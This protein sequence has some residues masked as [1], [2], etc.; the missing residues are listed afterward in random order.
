MKEFILLVRLPLEYGADQAS[1]VR[2][3][4]TA[5]TDQWKSDA[6]FVTSFVFPGE[7]HIIS[8]GDKLSKEP[9][10]SDNRRLI[11]CIVL[12]AADLKTALALANKCPVLA[13]EGMI[14]LREIMPRVLQ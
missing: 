12:K 13:Q 10:T 3:Q 9:A 6:L 11:S 7:S 4:W 1:A 8:N 14:E 2:A 5:V